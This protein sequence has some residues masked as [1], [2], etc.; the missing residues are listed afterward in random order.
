MSL[1]SRMNKLLKVVAVQSRVVVKR[2]SLRLRS[3]TN[4]RVSFSF[5][6][7]LNE[8]LYDY[9]SAH[10]N[11]TLDVS[12]DFPP[13]KSKTYTIMVSQLCSFN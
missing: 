2:L 13:K 6:R 10:A 5:S 11:L 12:Y 1:P 9:V 7:K 3:K 4:E 8:R